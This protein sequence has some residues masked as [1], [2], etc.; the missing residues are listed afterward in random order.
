MGDV[1]GTEP[2]E[3]R[4]ERVRPAQ[5]HGLGGHPRPA[6]LE[7]AAA[8]RHDGADTDCRAVAQEGDE[9]VHDGVGPRVGGTLEQLVPAVHDDEDV[10]AT[11]YG[12][13]TRVGA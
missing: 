5:E 11:A 6:G 1:G 10:R 9:G 4:V 3:R 7:Q 13:C 8:T 2:G 12:P